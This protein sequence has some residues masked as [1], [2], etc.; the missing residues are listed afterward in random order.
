MKKFG[1]VLAVAYGLASLSL[2][3]VVA[4]APTHAAQKGKDCGG[5]KA[6]RGGLPS[7]LGGLGETVINDRLRKAGVRMDYNLRSEVKTLLT[8]SLA[9]ALTEREQDQAVTAQRQAL[10]GCK[11]GSA[12]RTAWTSKERDGVTGG[13]QV[14]KCTVVAGQNCA[15]SRTFITDVDGKEKAVEQELC[16]QSD[17]TWA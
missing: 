15:V 9:C 5:K 11:S 13:T 7:V 4:V 10:N 12:R 8:N 2:T 3:S 14:K 17:G 1:A 16:E 6:E